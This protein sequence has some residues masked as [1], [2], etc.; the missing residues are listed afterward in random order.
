MDASYITALAALGG[1]ALGGFTSFVTSW[2]TSRGQLQAQESS[3]SKSRR[4]KLYKEF[5][6]KAT[7]MY[8]DALSH[9]TLELSRFIGLYAL[10]SR[11]RVLSSA[12]VI[13]SAVKV[14][15]SITTIYHQPNKTNDELE[16]LIRDGAVDLLYEFSHACRQEFESNLS[17]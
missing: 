1:A 16:A 7:E 9:D 2:T 15:R 4:Q 12:D 6:D 17:I 8:G 13:E 10:I 11:M 3:T 14:A 5:I